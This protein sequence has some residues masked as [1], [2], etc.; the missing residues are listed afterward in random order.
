MIVLAA[1]SRARTAG[2]QRTFG[3]VLK[4]QIS[5]Q[6]ELYVTPITIILSALPQAILSYTLACAQLS[7]WKQHTLIIGLLLTYVPLEGMRVS[8]QVAA[9]SCKV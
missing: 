2:D 1:R 6:K 7:H 4:K 3:E 8:S 9:I 5:T